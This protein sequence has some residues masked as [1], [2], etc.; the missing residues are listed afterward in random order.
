MH[1]YSCTVL[2]K[3]TFSEDN[4]YMTDM[5]SVFQMDAQ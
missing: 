4:F 3:L 5:A 2:L 1:Y